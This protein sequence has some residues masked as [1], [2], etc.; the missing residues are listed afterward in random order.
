MKSNVNNAYVRKRENRNSTIINAFVTYYCVAYYK[1][2]KKYIKREKTQKRLMTAMVNEFNRLMREEFYHQ[3][4]NI[5]IAIANFPRVVEELGV[6]ME[7][8]RFDKLADTVADSHTLADAVMLV[9]TIAYY[10]VIDDYVKSRKTQKRLGRETIKGYNG[11]VQAGFIKHRGNV[12]GI[13][14]ELRTYTQSK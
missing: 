1:I 14:E 2:V 9:M 3:D 11:L 6:D 8:H 13:I 5:R 10:N 12:N 4:D 7:I